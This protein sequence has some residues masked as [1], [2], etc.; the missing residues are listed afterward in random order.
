VKP[1]V[2][3]PVDPI[4][5]TRLADPAADQPPKDEYGYPD[6]GKP[7]DFD[8]EKGANTGQQGAKHA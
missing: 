3:N 4:E 7:F 5:Q 6:N 1:G 8:K 2:K